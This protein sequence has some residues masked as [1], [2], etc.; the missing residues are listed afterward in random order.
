RDGDVIS[1]DIPARRLDVKLSQDEL[2]DR[3][4]RWR[5][6]RPELRGYLARYF[7]LVSGAED[8]AVLL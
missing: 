2:K 7:R 6:P 1:I 5:P 3:R 4:E 8:G